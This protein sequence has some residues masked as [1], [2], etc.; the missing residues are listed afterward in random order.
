IPAQNAGRAKHEIFMFRQEK[1]NWPLTSF[2]PAPLF[3]FP[4]TFIL[5]LLAA[6]HFS[7]SRS[8]HYSGW[9]DKGRSSADTILTGDLRG[10]I[11]AL[12]LHGDDAHLV[13]NILFLWILSNAV[14]G[15]IG[16]GIGWLFILFSGAGGNLLNALFYQTAHNSIGAST[17]LFGALGLVAGFRLRLNSSMDLSFK[18]K[19]L[20]LLPL[21][22]LLA[23]TGADPKSDIMAHFFGC[24]FGT[25]LG[26]SSSKFVVFELKNNTK[27]QLGALALFW[28]T[29]VL[30][31]Q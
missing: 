6:F 19:Y 27:F 11:T 16:Y 2:K 13:G 1:S 10:T 17:A 15:Y 21:F 29:I 23:L 5:A 8:V 31:W 25:I 9:L 18:Q 14:S 30:A 20:P 12:T 4:H 26:L 3:T 7:I 22:A 28:F 24:I